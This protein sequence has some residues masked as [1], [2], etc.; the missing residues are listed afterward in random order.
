VNN[1]Y[2]EENPHP[3]VHWHMRP[4]YAKPVEFA[5]QTFEDKEFLDT[6]MPERLS[7]KYLLRFS[8][9]L[10]KK[11]EIFLRTNNANLS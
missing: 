8:I 6:T 11:L 5:G 4:R 9:K 2:Q 1:A 10:L 3:E 7:R